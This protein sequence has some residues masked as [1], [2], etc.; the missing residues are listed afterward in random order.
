M[1]LLIAG[2]LM[3]TLAHLFP[4]LAKPTRDRLASQ[5][6]D[7]PYQGL[8]ALFILSSIIVIVFG[9]KAAQPVLLYMPLLKPGLATSA[10]MLVAFVLFIASNLRTNVKRWIR[11]PQMTG[12]LIW[13]IAH[14][15]ANGDNR[16]IALFGSLAVW[17]IVEMLFCNRRDGPWQKPESVSLAKDAICVIIGAV[18][19]A[20]FAYSHRWLFGVTVMPPA[21][22][23]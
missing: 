2:I 8:F 4:A 7:G 5:L 17:S 6:G 13:S 18:L 15:L 16:S 12:T 22:G 1:T 10:L 11:H 23:A 14:L 19:F 20:V 3:F 21:M 9:W